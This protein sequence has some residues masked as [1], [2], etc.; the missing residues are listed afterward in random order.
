MRKY[1]MAIAAA[2]VFVFSGALALA[3][4]QGDRK[5]EARH[6]QFNDHDQKVAR[7]WYSQHR[8]HAPAGL[9]DKDRLSAD[10]ESRLH[11]GAVLDKNLRRKTHAAPRDLVRQLPPPERNDRYVA[12]GGHIGLV[13]KENH[14][15]GVIHLHENQ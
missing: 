5:D 4:D 3:Q 13:D 10:E 2:A 1:R 6:T 9:R 8:D 7:D 14:V 11:E 15:K 12:I